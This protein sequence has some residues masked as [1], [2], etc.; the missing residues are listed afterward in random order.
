ME[1]SRRLDIVDPDGSIIDKA[2][3]LGVIN[4]VFFHELMESTT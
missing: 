4:L 2:R 3:F 1:S